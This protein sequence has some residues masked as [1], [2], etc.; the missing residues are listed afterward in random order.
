VQ[1]LFFGYIKGRLTGAS[2]KEPDQLFQAIDAIFQPIKNHIGKRVS[3][4]DGQIG[5]MFCGTR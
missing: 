2:F 5:A 1:L 4:V 3:G